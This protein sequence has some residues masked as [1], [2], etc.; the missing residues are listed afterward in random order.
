MRTRTLRLVAVLL[1]VAA[2]GVAAGQDLGLHSDDGC[3][4]EVHCGLCRLSYGGIAVIG[5]A[6]ALPRPADLVQPPSAGDAAFLAPVPLR[7]HPPRGPP[8]PS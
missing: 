4:V 3:R 5:V 7:A 1:A 2:V 6:A 8:L